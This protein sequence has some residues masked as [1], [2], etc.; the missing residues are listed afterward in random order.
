MGIRLVLT[1]SEY[2][3]A[4]NDKENIAKKNVVRSSL[5]SK[6]ILSMGRPTRLRNWFES[7]RTTLKGFTNTPESVNF[8]YLNMPNINDITQKALDEMQKGD[9]ALEKLLAKSLLAWMTE[10]DRFFSISAFQ[11]N[12]RGGDLGFSE[13]VISVTVA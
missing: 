5:P 8:Y 7:S 2:V 12:V 13:R 3:S 1:P 4:K 10:G 9:D 6:P 11:F